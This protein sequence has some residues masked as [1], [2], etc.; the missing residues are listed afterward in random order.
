[1]PT[2]SSFF[3]SDTKV[4]P[5]IASAETFAGYQPIKGLVDIQRIPINIVLPLASVPIR[6]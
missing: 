5:R 3:P 1:M 4:H 6:T 2:A